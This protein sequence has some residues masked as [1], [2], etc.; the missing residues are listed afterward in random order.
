MWSR[1]WVLS[2]W[3]VVIDVNFY[4]FWSCNSCL[5]HRVCFRA[6]FALDVNWWF[7]VASGMLCLAP[8]CVCRADIEWF[9]CLNHLRYSA[10]AGGA[11]SH[12]S[13]F[14]GTNEKIVTGSTLLLQR[15][16]VLIFNKLIIPDFVSACTAISEVCCK[17]LPDCLERKLLDVT[18]REEVEST[19]QVLSDADLAPSSPTTIASGVKVVC[20]DQL[21]NQR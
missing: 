3:T 6:T 11:F 7:S 16:V 8:H 18:M 20:W 13:I 14:C 21:I 5:W 15:N 17:D 2:T 4:Q 12:I 10:K 9:G 1:C 19:C